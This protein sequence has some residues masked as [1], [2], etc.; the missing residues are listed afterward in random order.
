MDWQW[1]KKV[2]ASG[3]LL[4]TCTAAP[5]LALAQGNTETYIGAGWG[6][7]TNK[8]V[9]D[10]WDDKDTAWKAFIGWDSDKIF[11]IEA[12]Y[13]DFGKWTGPAGAGEIKANGWN[14]DGR[15]GIPFMESRGSVFVKGG[16]FMSD[17]SVNVAGLSNSKTN[18]DYTYGVGAEFDFTKNFG[19]RAEWERF[20]LKNDL[21]QDENADIMSASLVWKFK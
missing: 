6:Q 19:A 14:I 13:V 20:K 8:D 2:W 11:G 7:S 5:G 10:S 3:A 1:N 4:L 17:V 16:A 15:L 12:G 18:W 9:P 21:I